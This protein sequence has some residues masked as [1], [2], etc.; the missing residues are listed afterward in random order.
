[1]AKRMGVAI[2]RPA[3]LARDAW[4]AERGVLTLR[5]PASELLTNVDGVVRQV[6]AV[7]AERRDAFAST[8]LSSPSVTLRAP[9]PPGG[10]GLF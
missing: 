6:L 7:A 9:P 2:A 3:M 10:G 1:M 5:Y 4:F 8:S